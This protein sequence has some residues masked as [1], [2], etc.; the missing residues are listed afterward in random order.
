MISFHAVVLFFVIFVIGASMVFNSSA[1]LGPD[2]FTD[3]SL[4]RAS[5]K[6]MKIA[7]FLFCG[8]GLLQIYAMKHTVSTI[9]KVELNNV[10]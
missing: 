6:T 5:W 8:G 4:V 1:L 3:Y 2:N 7:M 9:D 10:V